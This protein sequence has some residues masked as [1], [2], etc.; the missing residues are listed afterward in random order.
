MLKAK[1]RHLSFS[2]NDICRRIITGY[3]FL[4]LPDKAHPFP[5]II[6][7]YRNKYTPE[8]GELNVRYR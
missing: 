8:K 1:S 6:E 7:L 4:K 5:F 3:Y 2:D